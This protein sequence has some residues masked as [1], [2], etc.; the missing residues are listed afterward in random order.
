MPLWIETVKTRS[1]E[2]GCRRKKRLKTPQMGELSADRHPKVSFQ[3][4]R[5]GKKDAKADPSRHI[6]K[7]SCLV[8]RTNAPDAG[9]ERSPSIGRAK[10][11]NFQEGEKITSPR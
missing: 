9:E 7:K 2:E 11:E 5:G 8:Q 6:N 10:K 1:R 4:L 3:K